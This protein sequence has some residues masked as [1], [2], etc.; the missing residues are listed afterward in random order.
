MPQAIAD[1]LSNAVHQVIIESKTELESKAQ[2][3]HSPATG[4]QTTML[5]NNLIKDYGDLIA[6][7]KKQQKQ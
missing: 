5:V 6:L 7:Y 3:I 4:K 2:V 1:V